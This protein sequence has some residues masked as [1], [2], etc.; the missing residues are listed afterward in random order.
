MS[1]FTY[2]PQPASV[3]ETGIDRNYLTNLLAKTLSLLGVATP[4]VLSDKLK[5]SKSIIRNLLDEMVSQQLAE[6]RGLEGGDVKGDIRYSLTRAGHERVQEHSQISQYVGPAPV[7]LNKFIEQIQLQSIQHEEIHHKELRDCLDH[8][9]LNKT[10]MLQLGPAVNSARSVLL[11]GEPG[12]GKTSIAEALGSSF[13]DTIY[14]PYAI[15]MGGQTIVFY[16]ETIHEIANEIDAAEENPKLD[17]RWVRCK[18]PVV[19][20]GGELTLDMLDLSYNQ[21]AKFYEAPVHVKAL[22]GIF[23]IDDFG[24]QQTPPRDILNRWI[25]PLEK[26]HDYLKLHT[27]MKIQIPF[28]QLVVFS[29]NMSPEEISDGAALR[30]IYFKI[31]IPSPKKDQYIEIFQNACEKLEIAFDEEVI[32]GFY[33]HFYD[34]EGFVTSGAHP[35]FLLNHIIAVSAYHDKE[36]KLSREL[37]DLAWKNVA[38]DRK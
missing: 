28:D 26:G 22:G 33:E 38:A 23:I 11:Y 25:V 29:T 19:I 7:S 32:S 2:P 36:P 9:V 10:L 1:S 3:E 15:L 6:S 35:E 20:T 12:N 27:G 4:A 14:L 37:L 16:D 24:R 13:S 8:L 5:L 21:Q 18:R 30:R 17:P 34:K 31:H